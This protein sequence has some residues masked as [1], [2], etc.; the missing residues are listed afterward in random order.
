MFSRALILLSLALPAKA[1]A[2]PDVFFGAGNAQSFREEEVD[3]RFTRSAVNK[4]LL[5]G[6][7]KPACEELVR[8]L[9]TVLAEAAP[10]L[11]KRDQN[12]YVDPVLVHSLQTQVSTPRFPATAYLAAMVRRVMIDKKMP[13]EWLQVATLVNPARPTIDVGKLRFLADGVK[14]IDSFVFTLPALR[15]RYEVE[16]NRA[17]SIAHDTA[18]LE[19][20]ESYLDRDVAWG[21]LTLVDIGPD[22]RRKGSEKFYGLLAYLEWRPPQVQAPHPAVKEFLQPTASPPVKVY[23]RLAEQQYVD[24]AKLP[25]GKRLIARGRLWDFGNRMRE[26]ELRDALLFEDRNW[27]EGAFIADPRL[28]AS[29]PFARNELPGA[30]S[31]QPGGF[32]QH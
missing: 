25:R 9:L 23:A 7:D 14:P 28:V 4:A 20:R 3:K 29:C 15:E 16:V 26:V 13:Q 10:T 22:R 24:V 12:F 2:Q 30:G 32:A 6:T 18:E 17:N 31:M 21:D 11:H 5:R 19:F 1:L 27:A 8:G